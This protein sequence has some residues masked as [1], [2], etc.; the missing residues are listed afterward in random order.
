MVHVF[1]H[2]MQ[3]AEVGRSLSSR[4]AWS[5]E[6]VLGQSGLQRKILSQRRRRRRKKKR[7]K[8]RRKR[9]KRKRRRRRKKKK[10]EKKKKS[11]KKGSL[12]EFPCTF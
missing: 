9:R 3:E 5:T 4:P 1:N 11:K 7:R 6:L 12:L 8:R 2:S 10:K